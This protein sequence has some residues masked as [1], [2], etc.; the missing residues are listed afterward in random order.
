MLAGGNVDKKWRDKIMEKEDGLRTVECLRGRLLAE[1]VASRVAK[2]DAELMGS[3]LIE[4]ERQIKLETKSRNKA[5]KKLKFLMKK[6]ESLKISPILDQSSSSENSK[7]SSRPSTTSSGL[8]EPEEQETD[9][10]TANSVRCNIKEEMGKIADSITTQDLRHHIS[11]T[12]MC[13]MPLIEGNSNSDGECTSREDRGK[14]KE[15]LSSEELMAY[16]PSKQSAMKEKDFSG[17]NNPE[18]HVDNRLALVPVSTLPASQI[19]EPQIDNASVRDVLAALR[20]AR[21][22]L[23]SSMGRREVV[24]S[25]SVELCSG[26]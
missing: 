12:S 23:Q 25:H 16:D 1:R 5:E 26:V 4:L 20:H 17:E 24:Y 13:K 3:Q 22:Q 2:E 15:N 7:D 21:K 14:L 6:L 11:E 18:E 9:S 10:R 19:C 8:K